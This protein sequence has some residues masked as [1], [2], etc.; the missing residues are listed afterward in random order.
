VNGFVVA[1]F[2]SEISL[3]SIASVLGACDLGI[4]N[5][6]ALFAENDFYPDAVKRCDS[7]AVN[8]FFYCERRCE[9]LQQ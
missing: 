2:A 9:P 3:V 6:Y 4:E 7:F 1:V 5:D 8:D